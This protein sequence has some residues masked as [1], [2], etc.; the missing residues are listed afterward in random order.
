MEDARCT[1]IHAN[2]LSHYSQTKLWQ[3]HGDKTAIVFLDQ[4]V[5]TVFVLF[6]V[7]V[8]ASTK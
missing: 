6:S 1:I 5:V 7:F 4:P 8:I 3:E 2:N